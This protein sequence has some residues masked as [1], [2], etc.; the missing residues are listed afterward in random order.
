LLLILFFVTLTT[1]QSPVTLIVVNANIHTGSK[2]QQ[3]AQAMAISGNKIVATGT[4]EQIRAMADEGTKTLDAGGK[5]IV[6][7][8]NDAH[9]HFTETGSQLSSVDLRDAKTPA[10]VIARIKAF[11]AKLPKGRWILGG[12]WDHEN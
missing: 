5:T 8:F 3:K 1:A 2:S 4:N 12:K 11:A 9:V 6:A 10:E 7:G